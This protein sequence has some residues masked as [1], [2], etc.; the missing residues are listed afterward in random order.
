MDVFQTHG[1]LT[2][3]RERLTLV[4]ADPSLFTW[5]PANE[6][7][8]YSEANMKTLYPIVPYGGGYFFSR[9]L[10]AFRSQYERD[11]LLY[12]I[13]SAEGEQLMT[14]LLSQHH[15]DLVIYTCAHR[16]IPFQEVV[17][18]HYKPS[19]VVIVDGNDYIPNGQRRQLA[20][21]ATYFQREIGKDCDTI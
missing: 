9:R 17:F 6:T 4:G 7:M 18:Q 5:S 15:F 10:L 8:K 2:V 21:H 13:T 19:E 11:R 3:L 16:T 1:W 14:S 20:K 12:N